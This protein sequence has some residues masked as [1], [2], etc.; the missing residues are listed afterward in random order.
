MK[1]KGW[2]L[3]PVWIE[4][5]SKLE[6]ERLKRELERI[7]LGWQQ[8]QITLNAQRLKVALQGKVKF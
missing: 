3:D 1:P 8:E 2:R 6:R 4:H 5:Y 7:H